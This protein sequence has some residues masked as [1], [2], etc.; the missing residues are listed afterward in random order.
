[1]HTPDAPQCIDRIIDVFPSHQQEQ[2]RVQLA[3]CLEGIIAQK[4]LPHRNGKGR[5]VAVEVLVAT[6]A[7]RNLIR[8]ARTEQIYGM[9]QTGSA[10]GMNLMDER[11]KEL[12]E[13]DIIT[14]E[15]AISRARDPKSIKED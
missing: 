15:T 12:Y 13:D 4:L 10:M 9:M 11:L 6:S 14:Y 8:E 3:S 7:I 2:I 5:V 1:V